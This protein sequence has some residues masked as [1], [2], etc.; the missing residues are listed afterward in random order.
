MRTLSSAPPE[1]RFTERER[2]QPITLGGLLTFILLAGILIAGPLVLGGTRP[3]FELP[4]LE[5]V[6]LLLLIQAARIG[7]A[8]APRVRIDLIDLSVVVFVLYAVVR[9]LTSPAEYYSRLEILNVVAYGTI[10]FTCRYGLV[11]RSFGLL[12]LGLFIVLGV[13]EAGFGYYLSQNPNWFPFG[14]NE[15]ANQ[16]SARWIGTYGSANH[17]GELLVLCM[18]AAL[19][20]GSFSKL[21]WP[22]RIV[23]FY[24]AALMLVGVVC[25]VSRGS[26]MGAFASITALA[27]FGVRYG[28]VRWWVPVGGG[29]LLLGALGVILSQSTLVQS[30]IAEV[31]QTVSGGRLEGYVR[32][33][34]A[35]DA[36]R[37]ASDCPLFGTG[38]ATFVFIHPR[39]QDDTFAR[40]AVLT[41]NDYLNT[42][43]DYGAVGLGIVLFFVGAVTVRYFRR[44]RAISRWQDRVL[45]TAG[46]TG[47]AALLVHSFV[48]YNMHIPANAMI[49]LALTGMAM[50]RFSSE[51]DEPRMGLS[52][53]RLPLALVLA[54]IGLAYGFEVGRTAI[55]DLIYEH[56]VAQSPD[57]MPSDSVDAAQESLAFDPGN[58]PALIFLGDI[59]R[60]EAAHFEDA[61]IG[62]RMNLGV[63]AA[64]AYEEAA[65]KNPLDDTIEASLGLTFDIMYRYPEA[66]FCY[67][68]VLKNQPYD[69]QFWFRLGNHFW[70][71]G[72]LEKAEQAYQMGLHC[73]NGSE[74]NVEPLHE[75]RGYLEAQGIPMP[76]VGTN[77]LNPNSVIEHPTV[78]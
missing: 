68:K 10:F 56:A 1:P 45:L 30:R 62:Q 3:W 19:A 35:R 13:F 18:G 25:S 22:V 33:K 15:T 41:H 43:D 48:D 70:E 42:L 76:P 57:T 63:K 73:P 53:P 24:L 64:D 77:P 32:I 60:V 36:L 2:R 72:M 28:M 27:V 21:S 38:P 14:P 71:T 65:L 55:S 7:F 40:R 61:N 78:P 67:V 20:F 8:A 51:S 12:L 11:R 31:T 37:I 69:G 4:L 29:V 58:V 59:Q 66:Y 23:L 9:W 54:V 44:P 6:A 50:R 74:E 75:I 49:L 34:L 46:F 39:Y 16:D 52:L 47:W 26:F 17:Y 5:V